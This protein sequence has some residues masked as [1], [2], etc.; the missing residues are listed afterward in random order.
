MDSSV[1]VLL[2]ALRHMESRLCAVLDDRCATPECR[3][4]EFKQRAAESEQ[5]ATVS[6]FNEKYADDKVPVKDREPFHNDVDDEPIFDEEF[7]FNV[8]LV[9]DEESTVYDDFVFNEEPFHDLKH[10]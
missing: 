1:E 5:C 9:V 2:A 4:T 8:E 7:I 3:V 6:I 10:R